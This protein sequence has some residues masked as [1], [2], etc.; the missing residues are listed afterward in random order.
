MPQARAILDHFLNVAHID[1]VDAWEERITGETATRQVDSRSAIEA[2]EDMLTHGTYRDSHCWVF[3]PHSFA[4]LMGRL[5]ETGHQPFR[6]ASFFPTERHTF[7]F[8]VTLE[9][10]DDR[11]RIMESWKTLQVEVLAQGGDFRSV[12][13][14]ELAEALRHADA[15]RAE[16]E[17]L[18]GHVPDHPVQAVESLKVTASLQQQVEN[19]TTVI[20]ALRGSTS[21]KVTAPLRAVRRLLQ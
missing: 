12:V 21:W 14:E 1:C 13:R 20:E 18:R 6:C 8:F 4:V 9:A 11:Q 7:E 16:V 5:A 19:L 10:C 3:T 15:L 17:R 2:A